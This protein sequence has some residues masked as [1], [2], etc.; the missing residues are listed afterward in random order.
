MSA[1]ISHSY[2]GNDDSQRLIPFAQR[3]TAARHAA[4][5]YYHP[6]DF[7]WQ[8]YPFDRS[9]DVRIWTTSR[10]PN[11]VLACAIFERSQEIALD[12]G[13]LF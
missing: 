8:L 9:D 12:C 3:V 11:A 1:Y 6:G 10:S 7:V 13:W 2:E 5:S 4:A